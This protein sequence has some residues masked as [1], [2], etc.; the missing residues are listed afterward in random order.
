MPSTPL[1]VITAVGQDRPGI[2]ASV[3]KTLWECGCNLEDTSSTRLQ[4]EFAMILLVRGGP[5]LTL[6]Q[7]ERRLQPVLEGLGLTYSFR[8]LSAE[9]MRDRE[10]PAPPR[11][12]ITVYGG[13]QPGIVH[14]V[15][16]LLASLSCNVTDLVTRRTGDDSSPLYIM[17]MEVE[18]PAGLEPRSV[19]GR[20]M[21]LGREIG[22]EISLQEIEEDVL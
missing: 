9:E 11:W 14:R 19:S 18:P 15:A 13:D 6:E 12:L 20:L 17:H 8:A 4:R 3:T 21:A 7:L 16:D 1:F 5:G 22:V 10:G 2:I